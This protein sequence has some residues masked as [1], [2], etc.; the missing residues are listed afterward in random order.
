MA[1]STVYIPSDSVK[2]SMKAHLDR[3]DQ[4]IYCR[5]Q[6]KAIIVMPSSDGKRLYYVGRRG[7]AC[8]CEGSRR[9]PLC[10]HM[11]AARE[12][13]THDA[14]STFIADAADKLLDE[15]E[16]DQETAALFAGFT[17]VESTNTGAAIEKPQHVVTAT[18]AAYCRCG[19]I[20]PREARSQRLCQ[21]CLSKG[22]ARLWAH[23]ED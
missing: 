20:I 3:R 19:Q 23:V 1:V 18:S 5:A 14:L 12:A 10:S 16:F 13:A 9:Y 11:W 17:R 6:G 21:A 4:W 2:A 15:Y 8:T 22:M 7:E